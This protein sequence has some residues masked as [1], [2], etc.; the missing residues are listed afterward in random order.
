M[1]CWSFARLASISGSCI[2]VRADQTC[3]PAYP[4]AA[5]RYESGMHQRHIQWTLSGILSDLGRAQADTRV[6]PTGGLDTPSG[7]L[8][9]DIAEVP[10]TGLD[11]IGYPTP[12]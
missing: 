10:I 11:L 6:T 5:A 1:F 7:A 8:K 2:P 3:V 4:R 9:P 12:Y